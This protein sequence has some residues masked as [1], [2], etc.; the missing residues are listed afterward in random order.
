[1]KKILFVTYDFPFPTTSGG[2]SRAYH[3]MK[4]GG[5]DLEMHLFSFVRSDFKEEYKEELEK[6]GVKK[7][8]TIFRRKLMH[9]GNSK[10][11][12]SKSH[13]IFYYLYFDKKIEEQLVDYVKT[14]KIDIVHFESFY[15]GFYISDSL[16][17]L[18]VRQI[19]GTENI[20]YSIYKDYVAQKAPIFIK[21]LFGKEA[22]KIQGEEEKMIK[23]SDMTLAVTKN[24]FDVVKKMNENCEI[25]ENGVDIDQFV[26][27][28]PEKTDRTKLLFVGNFSYFPNIDAIQFFY[29]E[30]FTKLPEK[31]TLTIIGKKVQ[32][33]G[34]SDTRV[35]L[36]E[37][38]PDVRTAYASADIFISPIRIGGGTNFKILEAMAMG[39]PVVAHSARV[40]DLGAT[41]GRELLVAEEGSAFIEQIELLSKDYVLSLSISKSAREFIEKRYA[42]DIIGKKLNT[43]WKNL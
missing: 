11:L 5:K 2:K 15:T 28:A 16:S 37:F 23:N 27:S 14:N 30:V 8:T 38:I 21:P 18:G 26:Y 31:F 13:S 10:A 4:F 17:K 25:V 12:L 41:S 36:I 20:E 40:D 1:M 24:D 9:P 43:L 29:K 22:L 42:W 19:F 3:M 6:I 7:I 32:E 35:S 33:L 39:L 34:I